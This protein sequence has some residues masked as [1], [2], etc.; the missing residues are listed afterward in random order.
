[1]SEMAPEQAAAVVRRML[2]T[3]MTQGA[4]SVEPD[5][6]T[7]LHLALET[8]ADVGG[9]LNRRIAAAEAQA[10]Q[11]TLTLLRGLAA[12]NGGTAAAWQHACDALDAT[13]EA[14]S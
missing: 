1:M 2:T 6:I 7:A 5:R 14:A 4:W 8:L 11:R 3:A 12:T 10:H 13:Q 9:S